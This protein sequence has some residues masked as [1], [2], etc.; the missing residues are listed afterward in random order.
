MN[1]HKSKI[2]VLVLC[3]IA[4]PFIYCFV[5]NKIHLKRVRTYVKQERFALAKHELDTVDHLSPKSVED[6]KMFLDIYLKS[7]DLGQVDYMAEL[8]QFKGFKD[9]NI[10]LHKSKSR[11]LRGDFTGALAVIGAEINSGSGSG[12]GNPANDPDYFFAAALL[13]TRVNNIQG[14]ASSYLNAFRLAGENLETKFRVLT[15]L[16]EIKATEQALAVAK[17]LA[18]QPY[19][20]PVPYL[21]L[22]RMFDQLKDSVSAKASFEKGVPLMASLDEKMRAQVSQNF[23]DVFQTFSTEA[24]KAKSPSKKEPAKQ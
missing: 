6:C 1:A 9:K 13:L 16:M 7:Y 11:E 5:K 24:P 19:S 10:I 2:V 23:Q 17:A 3:L 8:C 21:L 14:A 22:A 4:A 20:Q 18:S 12:S 15:G